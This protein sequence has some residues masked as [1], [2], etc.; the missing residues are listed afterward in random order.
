MT[1]P[2]AAPEAAV[3][4]EGLRLAYGAV[5]ALDGLSFTVPAGRITALLGPNGAGKTST[6]EVCEGYRSADSGYVR[7]WGL[8][9]DSPALRARVGWCF[10]VRTRRGG[11]S[12]KSTRANARRPN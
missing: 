4:V 2:D 7:V 12:H 11:R 6:V 9:P 3:V 5:Q 1:S 8:R 10:G